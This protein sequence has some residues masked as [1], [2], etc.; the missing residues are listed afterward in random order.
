MPRKV[1]PAPPYPSG[2]TLLAVY[3]VYRAFPQEREIV[4]TKVGTTWVHFRRADFPDS[5]HMGGRFSRDTWRIESG[6]RV[7]RDREDYD[8]SVKLDRRWKEAVSRLP[9]DRPI[10]T[11]AN[12]VSRLEDLV[13]RGKA[14]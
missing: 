8:E 3:S 14:L 1:P 4:A 13:Q 10:N 12:D 2:A 9:R 11:G 7:Y 5:P 6:G